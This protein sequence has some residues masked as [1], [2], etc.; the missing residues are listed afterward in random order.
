M[1]QHLK[2]TLTIIRP[3][4]WHC[5][6]R[7]GDFLKQTVRDSAHAFGRVVAMPNL[8]PPI[9]TVEQAL[10]Y[11]RNILKHN[12][13]K[14]FSP[15][16]TL[17]M[18]ESINEEQVKQAAASEH[19][20][21]I[22]LYPAGVTTASELGVH[23]IEG[24]FPILEQMEKYDL[25]L[26]VH[27]ES[28]DHDIDIFDREAHFIDHYLTKIIRTFPGLKVSLEHISTQYA[29]DF[30]KQQH[31]RVAATI[32]V[33][34]LLYNR[35]EMLAHGLKPH[36][37]CMPIL[38]AM[39]DQQALIQAAISGN[40]KFFLGTD[41]APHS[42]TNKC[43]SCGCA[44]IYA[45][46]TA[47]QCLTQVFDSHQALNKLEGFCSIFGAQF[48]EKALNCDTITLCRQSWTAP[49]VLNFGP[50]QVS[51]MASGQI[52]EWTIA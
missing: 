19:I 50:D 36:L 51:P 21:G 32:T 7:D 22:K 28:N 24:I 3:D 1:K 27:G 18:H 12:P 20:I 37:Y 46:P 2:Q 38:K 41:S 47:I 14:H 42:I 45:A 13:P 29:C 17:Y 5:H 34:H 43:S 6:F 48:Y 49:E 52:I 31:A 39:S 11:R 10:N 4:D 8:S 26:L 25:P 30:I 15:M 35:N 9:T 40:P 16:M 44:G 23:R 33:H